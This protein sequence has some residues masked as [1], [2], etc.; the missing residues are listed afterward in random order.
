M[1]DFLTRLRKIEYFLLLIAQETLIDTG[2]DELKCT[3]E[4]LLSWQKAGEF[5]KN[6]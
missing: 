5:G 2:S 6:S 1:E 3:C 4:L